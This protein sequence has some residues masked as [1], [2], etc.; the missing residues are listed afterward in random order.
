MTS[1]YRDKPT[2]GGGGHDPRGGGTGLVAS[3]WV[4]TVFFLLVAGV[5]SLGAWVV[6]GL[7]WA[8][9][10]AALGVL[11]GGTHVPFRLFRD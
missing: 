6:I 4:A 1:G 8:G 11:Q 5:T 2:R 9:V 7:L 3:A 10:A